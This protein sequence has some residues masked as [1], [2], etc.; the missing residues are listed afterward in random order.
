M[1]A[2]DEWLDF[3]QAT[4]IVVERLGCST[5]RAQRIVRDASASN[6]VR[7]KSILPSFDGFA[8]RPGALPPG[9]SLR[10]EFLDLEQTDFFDWLDRNHAV[11]A[12]SAP[13]S[14]PAHAVSKTA[15]AQLNRVWTEYR[16]THDKPTQREFVAKATEQG[17][18]DRETL[19]GFYNDKMG[20]PPR[21]RRRKSWHK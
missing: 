4:K 18:T 3:E 14:Q 9:A 12:T 8:L 21:G 7:R 16:A 2:A 1:M 11:A 5:G 17:I 6:D 15:G 10:A 20:H 19:R 13:S